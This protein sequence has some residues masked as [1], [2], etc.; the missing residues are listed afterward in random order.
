MEPHSVPVHTF[1]SSLPSIELEDKSDQIEWDLIDHE[2]YV[3]LSNVPYKSVGLELSG[4]ASQEFPTL[5]H[6]IHQFGHGHGQIQVKG[7]SEKNYRALESPLTT[8]ISVGNHGGRV[9][10]T[11]TAHI[12]PARFGSTFHQSESLIGRKRL[13]EANDHIIIPQSATSSVDSSKE[14][15]NR[16]KRDHPRDKMVKSSGMKELEAVTGCSDGLVSSMS[17]IQKSALSTGLRNKYKPSTNLRSLSTIQ[18]FVTF[19]EIQRTRQFFRRLEWNTITLLKDIGE[20][21]V[22][23][24]LNISYEISLWFAK[25]RE[26]IIRSSCQ[27]ESFSQHVY[28][29]IYYA[30]RWLTMSFLGLIS[31]YECPESEGFALERTLMEAWR[32][33]QVFFEEWRRM[34][35]TYRE[36]HTASKI[37]RGDW[38]E[39][40]Y[41]FHHFGS[42]LKST[43]P[44]ENV[45]REMVIK[46]NKY[47]NP[48]RI[49]STQFSKLYE[50]ISIYHNA[51][52]M[53]IHGGLY[54]RAGMS[55]FEIEVLNCHFDIAK[56]LFQTDDS[57]RNRMIKCHFISRCAQF[58]SPTGFELC[59]SVHIFFTSLIQSLLNKYKNQ[60]SINL[61]YT[62]PAGQQSTTELEMEKHHSNLRHII[63]GVS[64]AEYRVT[65][66][67]IG[68]VRAMYENNL[69][70]ENLLEIISSAWDYLKSVFLEWENLD[71]DTNR[72]FIPS[73]SQTSTKGFWTNP[74]R[75]FHG[76]CTKSNL[77]NSPI[78][79]QYLTELLRLWSR[80]LLAQDSNHEV[81]LDI[82]EK[83][84]Q[85]PSCLSWIKEV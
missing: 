21:F 64:I 79:I 78:P 40:I 9:E 5:S 25:L 75:A 80:R 69:S 63:R 33:M 56:Q 60:N 74:E 85:N 14:S 68:M 54:S 24:S 58:L 45:L 76:C 20:F 41:L 2:P 62:K 55:N 23:N 84:K 3:D 34:G 57:N 43:K 19:P 32:F 38:I 12:V 26:D 6:H 49:P 61:D 15:G 53:Y 29:A 65:V 50:T 83:F 16:N 18:T 67:F 70:K 47:R 11:G 82:E 66:G 46:W 17:L 13:Y 36:L 22:D 1:E 39:P 7:G 8:G 44:S 27:D 30:H 28:T 51:Q 4:R 71:F 81:G 10:T 35:R 31:I 77:R 52:F 37:F 48:S 73:K 72:F 59:Q 42:I